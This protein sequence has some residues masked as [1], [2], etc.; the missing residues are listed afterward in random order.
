MLKLLIL[1]WKMLLI[2]IRCFSSSLHPFHLR[3]APSAMPLIAKESRILTCSYNAFSI[4][5]HFLK[6]IKKHLLYATKLNI[7][8]NINIS[9]SL[10]LLYTRIALHVNLNLNAG[11]YSLRN[12][13]GQP[14]T[15]LIRA[16][17]GGASVYILRS[18]W[19]R[20]GKFWLK[21]G[22]SDVI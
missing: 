10:L 1:G 6:P 16:S 5:N 18:I 22:W 7:Y 11:S 3:T 19:M 17:M 9:L 21:L 20:S 12:D 8:I 2:K 13:L 4:R 15:L 14:S